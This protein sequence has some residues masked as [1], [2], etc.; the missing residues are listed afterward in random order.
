MTATSRPCSISARRTMTSAS[1][2]SSFTTTLNRIRSE[3]SAGSIAAPAR[4]SL[5]RSLFRCRP[6]PFTRLAGDSSFPAKR[7]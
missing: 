7:R 1:R 5:P 4:A 2:M 3:E 6:P